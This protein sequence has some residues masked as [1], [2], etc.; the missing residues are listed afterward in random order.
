MAAANLAGSRIGTRR[1]EHLAAGFMS[2][3]AYVAG[4]ESTESANASGRQ[5][6]SPMTAGRRLV[7]LERAGLVRIRRPPARGS[8]LQLA[9]HK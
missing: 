9:S 1:S 8:L 3:H 2:Y 5:Q 7:R 6:W 4:I